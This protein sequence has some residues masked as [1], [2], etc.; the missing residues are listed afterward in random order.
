MGAYVVIEYDCE[1]CGAYVRKS[2]SESNPGTPRFCSIKCK[3][4]AQRLQKPV[5]REWL[6]QKYVVEGLSAPEIARLV[7]RNAKRV[8][9]WLENEGIQ[10]RSRG[11]ESSPGTFRQGQVSP[12]KGKRHTDEF[13]AAVRQRRLTD[14]RVPYIKNGVH[15]LKGKR[16]TETPNWKGGITPERQAFYSSAEWVEA[17]K[18]IWRRDDA[19]CQ[20]CGIDHRTINRDDMKFHIHHID[21]FANRALRAEP[22]NLILLCDVCHR[23]VHSRAN[24]ERKFLA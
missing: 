12:F 23:W 1:M 19:I 4:A 10:T 2:V 20:R 18:T 7:G 9:E 3:A 16:G 8:W 24:T 14:G 11:A 6:V 15:H 17:V 22:S 13:R 5:T 21:S